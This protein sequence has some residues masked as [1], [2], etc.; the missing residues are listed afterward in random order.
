MW[1]KAHGGVDD[2]AAI[3]AGNSDDDDHGDDVDGF[4]GIAGPDDGVRGLAHAV[5]HEV[6][7]D[8]QGGFHDSA[9]PEDAP[10]DNESKRTA[11]VFGRGSGLSGA[12]RRLDTSHV[13]DV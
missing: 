6:S 5:A 10:G 13:D 7:F 3:I 4:G 9:D 8:G 2:E 1:S 12:F 11:I